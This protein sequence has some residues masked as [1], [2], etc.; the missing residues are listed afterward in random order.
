M[1]SNLVLTCS[2]V[3][4]QLKSEFVPE[5]VWNLSRAAEI[6]S[7]HSPI[8]FLL[9]K[10]VLPYWKPFIALPLFLGWL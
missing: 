1:L 6:L 7:E 5:F 10:V 9:P 3:T 8:R 2:R 4:S